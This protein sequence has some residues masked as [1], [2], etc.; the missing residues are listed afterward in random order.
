MGMAAKVPTA[1]RLHGAPHHDRGEQWREHERERITPRSLR[2]PD[3]H[4]KSDVN[5]L[6]NAQYEVVEQL[7]LKDLGSVQMKPANPVSE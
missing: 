4:H 5:A 1:V 2:M 7:G 6:G 3:S